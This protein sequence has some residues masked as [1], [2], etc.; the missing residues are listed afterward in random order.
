MGIPGRDA[1]SEVQRLSRKLPALFRDALRLL[2]QPEPLEAAQFYK[3]FTA[4][5]HSSGNGGGNATPDDGDEAPL[6]PT[7]QEVA[8]GA[9]AAAESDRSAAESGKAGG[10]PRAVSASNLQVNEQTKSR[11]C[12]HLRRCLCRLACAFNR[13]GR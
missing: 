5:A 10:A 2:Q 9:P 7:L 11:R 12:S 4:F 8:S 13:L 6:L 3:A 1:R